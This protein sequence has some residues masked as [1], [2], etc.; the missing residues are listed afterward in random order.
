[1][2]CFAFTFYHGQSAVEELVI[3]DFVVLRVRCLFRE[4]KFQVMHQ[5]SDGL[6]DPSDVPIME[7]Y[8]FCVLLTHDYLI[9]ETGK[10]FISIISLQIQLAIKYSF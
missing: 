2:N 8:K 1:M 5:V 6:G 3:I 4:G 7:D 9:M 10:K